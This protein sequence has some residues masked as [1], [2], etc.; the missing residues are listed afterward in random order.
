M[1][2]TLT[3]FKCWENK[4]F[5]L[6]DNGTVLISGKSGKGKTSILE[7]INFVLFG[8]GRKIVT[9]GH[10]KC[11]VY[12]EYKN[13]KITRTRCPNRL[14]LIYNNIHYEDDAAQEIVNK[15][16]GKFFNIIGYMQQNSL[17][18]FLLLN[19]LEKLEFLEKL[20]FQKMNISNIKRKTKN[21]LKDRKD[22]LLENKS[23]I[24]ILTEIIQ[25]KENEITPIDKPL[26]ICSLK[27]AEI[28]YNNSE[29]K[30]KNLLKK[31]KVLE[32]GL[33]STK[34]LNKFL[35]EFNE[36]FNNKK[37]KLEKLKEKNQNINIDEITSELKGLKKEYKNLKKLREKRQLVESIQELSTKIKNIDDI[38]W[39][40]DTKNDT[41]ENV[42][43]FEQYIKDIVTVKRLEKQLNSLI[44]IDNYSELKKQLSLSKNV[45]CPGCN[46][47]L[48]YDIENKLLV[49]SNNL[50]IS[51]KEELI[52]K[53]KSHEN[54][55]KIKDR[56][57]SQI[58]E[59][60][61]NYEEFN[62]DELNDIC[63]D[64]KN[65]KKYYDKNISLE[66]EKKILQKS[67]I[68]KKLKLKE[69]VDEI[70]I[71]CNLEEDKLLEKISSLKIII[72]NYKNQ[73]TIITTLNQELEHLSLKHKKELDIYI[74][75]YKKLLKVTQ[76][77]KKITEKET[78]L[79]ILENEKKY[80][81]QQLKD[82]EKY[83]N[84][85]KILKGL[86]TLQNK[87]KL[88]ENNNKI[89]RDKL[90]AT[91]LLQTK[92]KE[93]E[94][95]SI[96]NIIQSINNYA[97]NYL[98]LFFIEDL[99]TVSLLSF[100]EDKKPKIHIS[101]DYKGM[102]CELKMLSG[103]E[104]QRIVLA[105]NLAL[106]DMFNLP[107]LLLDE[108]TSNLDQELTNIVINGIKSNYSNK[109]VI[110]IAHQVIS[111]IFDNVIEI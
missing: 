35:Q 110:L 92:I 22:D 96:S 89:L 87:L 74:K 90:S 6:P 40:N 26:K 109:L 70:L 66:Y 29:V 97:K 85:K 30:I 24:Q 107:L 64:M 25:N 60:K 78:Q 42:E 72:E 1:I 106:S 15:F 67:L 23:Q 83:Q 94:S 10:K 41:K 17:N 75:K 14:H 50:P 56:L 51:N 111:G 5:N 82:I 63:D 91:M 68:K 84:Y 100:N 8:K 77:Q 61:S 3:Y 45:K 65:F 7:A 4:I 57:T 62:I 36:N 79:K 38:L 49:V 37:D 80:N 55:L 9:I 103:G 76:F 98:D 13:F 43:I 71:D 18:S 19:P 73:N 102:N 95:I 21:L 46:I 12:L 32:K 93:A 44:L 31:I 28:R 34:I 27:N 59:I 108:S 104:I 52:K 58:N 33:T 47:S 54:N 11:K 53:I 99:I 2:L 69:Y 48:N 39:K 20:S 81:Y 88:L 101:I 16:F 105:F 86:K